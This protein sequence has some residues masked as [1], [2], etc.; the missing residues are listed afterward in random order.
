MWQLSRLVVFRKIMFY[1]KGWLEHGA[2]GHRNDD[3]QELQPE[4][5]VF[6]C[7]IA[8]LLP[9]RDPS[10]FVM[11]MSSAFAVSKPVMSPL[12]ELDRAALLIHMSIP[13]NL[14]DAFL[15]KASTWSTTL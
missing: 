10:M 6:I 13:P 5:C 9:H 14:S 15:A 3:E 8:A 12:V 2:A 1:A 4:G 7:V 11:T